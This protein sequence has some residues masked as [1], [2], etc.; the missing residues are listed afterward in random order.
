MEIHQVIESEVLRHE[1]DPVRGIQIR[2]DRVLKQGSASVI[3]DPEFGEFKA[4]KDGTFDVPDGLAVT[5][6]CQP[7]WH[8]GPNPFAEPEE[9]RK[10]RAKA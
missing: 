7:G 8:E 3:S 4:D 10:A 9:P 1:I 5:L 6:L 2:K